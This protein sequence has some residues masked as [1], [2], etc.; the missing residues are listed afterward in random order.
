MNKTTRSMSVADHRR[1]LAEIERAIA[2]QDALLLA[3][4][5][6]LDPRRTVPVSPQTD[7]RFRDLCAP[8]ERRKPLA[9]ATFNDWKATRC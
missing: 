3:A 7:G 8:P 1:A 9:A 4:H 2:A 6:A 5:R